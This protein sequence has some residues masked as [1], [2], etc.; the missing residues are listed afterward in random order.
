MH[1]LLDPLFLQPAFQDA[2]V[3]GAR[4]P[5]RARAT[6]LSWS[7]SLSDR[8]CGG[9]DCRQRAAAPGRLAEAEILRL[10]PG[11]ARQALAER[12]QAEQLRLHLAQPHGHG[13]EVV[14]QEVLARLGLRI[15]DRAQHGLQQRQLDV[16]RVAEHHVGTWNE[17]RPIDADHASR[18][19]APSACHHRTSMALALESRFDTRIICTAHSPEGYLSTPWPAS[20][21]SANTSTRTMPPV[22]SHPRLPCSSGCAIARHWWFRSRCCDL[23][24]SRTSSR[25]KSL[26]SPKTTRSPRN[27]GCTSPDCW[28]FGLGSGAQVSSIRCEVQPTADRSACTAEGA[29]LT[30]AAADRPAGAGGRPAGGFSP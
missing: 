30:P 27:F 13:V 29:K 3:V 26:S 17:D 5:C 23:L 16:R 8:S 9:S 18:T 28:R 11:H 2:Q 21:R 20:P 6:R 14:A 25:E 1:A 19:A 22:E 12:V 24:R 15:G 7:N 4:F 10:H